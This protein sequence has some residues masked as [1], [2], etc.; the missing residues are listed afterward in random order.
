M[1]QEAGP[2]NGHETRYW[3]RVYGYPAPIGDELITYGDF[4]DPMAGPLPGEPSQHLRNGDVLIYYAD[5]PASLFGI[6][7][8]DGAVEGPI[9]DGQE[10][11]R[12]RVKIKL[13]SAI[14]S[15]KKMAHARGL[16]PPSGWH[17]LRAVRDYTFILLPDGDGPYLMEQVKSRAGTRGE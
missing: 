7:A 2:A 15:V 10:G 16:T 13:E 5:G 14:P 1:S 6:G 11:E 17:F 9:V 4:Y 3:L 12:W 8:V